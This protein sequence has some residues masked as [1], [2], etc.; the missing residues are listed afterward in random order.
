MK[1]II[2]IYCGNNWR[3]NWDEETIRNC[4]GGGSETWAVELS[5]EFQKL[6]FH[7]I[8]FGKPKLHHFSDAGVEY[9]PWQDFEKRCEYQHFDYFI[10]SR[11]SYEITPW[12]DCNNI[13]II[14]HD[15]EI[16][17][18]YDTP[19]LK[20]DRVKKIALLSDW[21]KKIYLANYTGLTEDRIFLTSNGVDMSLYENVDIGCKE[22]SMVWSSC[23][24]RGLQ[25]FLD[26]IFPEIKKEIPDFKL[27]IAGYDEYMENV[28]EGISGVEF[29]GK[30]NK[31]Q[32]SDLQKKSKIWIY[33]NIGINSDGQ[34]FHETFCITAVENAM[35]K[36]AIVA[37]NTGGIS[38]TLKGCELLSFENTFNELDFTYNGIDKVNIYKEMAN[39]AVYL[40]KNNNELHK[41]AE[42]AYNACKKYTW[43]KSVMDWLNE[44][45]LLYI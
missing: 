7:V 38:T 13:Y 9:V 31:K 30:L 34:L 26:Y 11:L 20:L 35:A 42:T 40:L 37:I 8:V 15:T 6:G 4:G 28:Y 18:R 25:E 44:W 36:N 3:S 10:S 1:K 41:N 39:R 29:V 21:Q 14:G 2:G 33:P 32:L 23:K 43:K 24:E 22:N 16:E 12:I 17:H 19:V 5:E 45:G 27:Y